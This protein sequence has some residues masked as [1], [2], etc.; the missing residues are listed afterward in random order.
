MSGF[1]IAGVVL[2]AFPILLEGL[3]FYVAEAGLVR[4][5]WRPERAL[6]RL[7]TDARLE[8]ANLQ[9]TIEDLFANSVDESELKKLRSGEGWDDPDIQAKLLDRLA[10]PYLVNAFIETL[11]LMNED[12]EFLLRKLQIERT[13][14]T[15]THGPISLNRWGEI[16]TI[17]SMDELKDAIAQ[18]DRHNRKLESLARS[19]Q[20]ATT[21]AV[22]SKTF[23]VKQFAA[24]RNHA[25]NLHRIFFKRL[26]EPNCKCGNPHYASLQLEV[27]SNISLAKGPN[28]TPDPKF[29]VLFYR[30]SAPPISWVA[31]EF[32]P[33]RMTLPDSPVSPISSITIKSPPLPVLPPPPPVRVQ[34]PPPPVQSQTGYSY[35]QELAR[36]GRGFMKR[37]RSPARLSRSKSKEPERKPIQTPSTQVPNAPKA[38]DKPKVA[39]NMPQPTRVATMPATIKRI[40]NFCALIHQS[41]PGGRGSSAGVLLDPDDG[42][43]KIWMIEIAQPETYLP[44]TI[45]LKDI[46]T[47]NYVSKCDRLALGVQLASSV[48]QLYQTEWLDEVWGKHDIFF[49]TRRKKCRVAGGQYQNVEEPVLTKP[50][51][52]RVPQA[53]IKTPKRATTFQ[54]ANYNTTIYFLGVVLAELALESNLEDLSPDGE[55]S[56]KQMTEISCKVGPEYG[57]AVYH[58]LWGQNTGSPSL[59]DKEFKTKFYEKVIE[60]LENIYKSTKESEMWEGNR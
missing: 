8:S 53:M 17:L 46:L 50:L 9:N 3:K 4:T 2:G 31:M 13:R 39:F 44:Q 5:L 6:R 20:L 29:T 23:P 26:S 11:H 48:I 27:R 15:G 24:V 30:E 21:S 25:M 59:N 35:T 19:R 34:T 41:T 1:E 54:L 22:T 52:R 45:P 51:L 58:C 28:G 32:E 47:P 10:K 14:E 16:K 12:L 57:A 43:Y 36:K 55:V 33:T 56:G 49:L 18:L 7:C 42:S 40:D 60:P 38:P 37:L